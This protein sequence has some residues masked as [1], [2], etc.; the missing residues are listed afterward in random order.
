LNARRI[1]RIQT[2]GTPP[3][4]GCNR[5][6]ANLTGTQGNESDWYL[7]NAKCEQKAAWW[8]AQLTSRLMSTRPQTEWSFVQFAQPTTVFD[9]FYPYFKF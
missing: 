2:N 7:I 1:K 9:M 6:V 4:A 8:E 5:S 3:F